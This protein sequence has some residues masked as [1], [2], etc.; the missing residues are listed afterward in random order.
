M[1]K[2]APSRLCPALIN[3]SGSDSRICGE[4]GRSGQDL[5]RMNCPIRNLT[6]ETCKIVTGL[7]SY[8]VGKLT[9]IHSKDMVDFLTSLKPTTPK[10]S[11]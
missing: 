11:I 10:Q 1:G 5:M 2:E 4:N 7:D 9:E 6:D 8:K 3:S